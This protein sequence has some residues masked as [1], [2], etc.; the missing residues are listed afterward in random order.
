VGILDH[1]T[2]IVD[3]ILTTEGRRQLSGGGID[4]AFYAFEDSDVIYDKASDLSLADASEK[5]ACEATQK[6]QDTITAPSD[7][8]GALLASIASSL[9]ISGGNAFIASGST[10][11]PATQDDHDDIVV[12]IDPTDALRFQ[13]LL[14]TVDS[15]EDNEFDVAPASVEFTLSDSDPLSRR[16][17]TQEINDSDPLYADPLLSHILNFA[18]LPPVANGKAQGGYEPIGP[19][20]PVTATEHVRALRD[21]NK[22]DV[23]MAP[24]PLEN[25]IAV[26]LFQLSSGKIAKLHAVDC[27]YAGSSRVVFYGRV[28]RNS[29][30]ALVFL[31]LFTLLIHR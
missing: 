30:N 14:Q 8:S 21:T 24:R 7:E 11:T 18:Y 22:I 26:Q 6:Q 3:A 27:G 17:Q 28:M 15:F 12:S 29:N 31:R 23:F 4:I 19:V 9:V 1:N 13:S 5:F 10:L 20:T 2:R 16:E 25:R